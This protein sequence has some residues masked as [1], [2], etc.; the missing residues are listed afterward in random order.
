MKAMIPHHPIAILTNKRAHIR[1]ARVCALA[2]QIIEAQLREIEEMKQLIAASR[3][4]S[5]PV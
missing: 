1:D 2:D 3:T 5:G 4:E